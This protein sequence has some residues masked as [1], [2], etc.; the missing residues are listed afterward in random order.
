MRA[1]SPSAENRKTRSLN[2]T[3][4]FKD[5]Y[6]KVLISRIEGVGN[7]AIR[8]VFNDGHSTGIYSWEYIYNLGSKTKNA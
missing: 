7:Y 1:H 2:K 8:I 5:E 4:N 6:K 3:K